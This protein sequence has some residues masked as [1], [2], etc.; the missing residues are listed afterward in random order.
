MYLTITVLQFMEIS[1]AVIR[2]NLLMVSIGWIKS[3][4]GRYS[5]RKRIFRKKIGVEEQISR[6][7]ADE[8]ATGR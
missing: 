7:V 6:L 5:R 4:L 1:P 2:A 3:E 8:A